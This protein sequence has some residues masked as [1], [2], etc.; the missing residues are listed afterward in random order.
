LPEI[1]LQENY[2]EK[3]NTRSRKQTSVY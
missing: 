3:N 2:E 1:Y